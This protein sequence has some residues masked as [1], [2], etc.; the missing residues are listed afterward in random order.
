LKFHTVESLRGVK[1]RFQKIKQTNA[2]ASDEP[3]A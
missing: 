3:A 1:R 2:P